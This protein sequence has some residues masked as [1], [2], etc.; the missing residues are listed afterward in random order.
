MKTLLISLLLLTLSGSCQ[1]KK[2]PIQ[3]N[4]P[5]TQQK[6]MTTTFLWEEGTNAPLG[7]PITVY[8]GG[9]ELATGFVGLNGSGYATGIDGWGTDANG[10][11]YGVKSLPK[12]INCIWLS[13]VEDCFYTID[14]DVDYDKIVRLFN[15]GFIE[16]NVQGRDTDTYS[17]IM[18]GF[19]PGG[20]VVLWV[21]GAGKKV[22]IGRYQGKKIMISEAEIASLDSH[23]HLLFD[24]IDRKRTLENPMIIPLEVQKANKNKPIPYGLWDTYRERYSWRPVFVIPDQGKMDDEVRM[25]MINGEIETPVCEIFH[26]NDYNQ[27]AIPKRFNFGWWDKNGQGYSGDVVFDE[28]EMATA[29]ENM[30]KDHRD[31]NVDIEIRVNKMNSFFTVRLKGNGKEIPV[32]EKNKIDVYKSEGLTEEYKK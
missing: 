2:Q 14:C 6:Q 27:R 22:E 28:K 4:Q 29:F 24:P 25:E 26:N 5:V 13:Y 9:L 12:R 16:K 23:E 11:S 18:T 10:M 20:V 3:N 8:R 19:A 17:K 30:Y 31:S 1:N 32:Y 7:Y 15:D 21:S